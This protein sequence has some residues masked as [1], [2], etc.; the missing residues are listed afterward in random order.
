MATP[1]VVKFV[2]ESIKKKTWS[3]PV[4]DLGA[5][6]QTKF[7]KPIFENVT[8]VTLDISQDLENH[9]DYLEDICNMP[10]V[11]SNFFGVALLL[12]TLEHLKSPDN[13]FAEISRILRPGGMFIC[14]T[15]ASWYKHEHPCD[16]W[17]FLPAGL[18]LLCKR[19]NFEIFYEWQTSQNYQIPCQVMFAAIKTK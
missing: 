14:T 2:Q 6:W 11:E 7:Y 17:R 3:G 5:G 10:S 4:I 9:I 13:A 16:Y 1:A 19:S 8:Y 18:R 12:E 15:V